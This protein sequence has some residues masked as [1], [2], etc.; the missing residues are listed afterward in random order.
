MLISL[1]IAI[2]HGILRF[3]VSFHQC[4]TENC[5]NLYQKLIFQSGSLSPHGVNKRFSFNQFIPVSH[6]TMFPPSGFSRYYTSEK[7]DQPVSGDYGFALWSRCTRQRS[8]WLYSLVSVA[9][10][11]SSV[12]GV[13]YNTTSLLVS[14]L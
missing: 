14:P 3:P 11:V 13:Y 4:Y 6:V 7:Q 2:K 1:I 9:I 5:K 8:L 10:P 12:G